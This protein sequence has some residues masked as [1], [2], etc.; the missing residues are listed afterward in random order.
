[1][2]RELFTE[3][4]L[5]KIRGGLAGGTIGDALGYP[6]EFMSWKAIQKQYEADGIRN[7]E[8]AFETGAAVFSD[9]TQMSLFTA[10]GI[11]IGETQWHLKGIWG[12]IAN[13]VHI[14]Y[15]ISEIPKLCCQL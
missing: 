6:V 15:R 8:L 12:A 9:D 7:Y 3:H 2:D 5:D 13:Y 10:N 14:A 11:L 4:Y 1:M